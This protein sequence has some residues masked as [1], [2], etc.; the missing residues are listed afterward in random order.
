MFGIIFVQQS[1][2]TQ[3]LTA[4]EHKHFYHPTQLGESCVQVVRTT[5]ELRKLTIFL[6]LSSTF[7]KNYLQIILKLLLAWFWYCSQSLSQSVCGLCLIF[8]IALVLEL[9][10]V[11]FPGWSWSLSWFCSW[12]W[13]EIGLNLSLDFCLGLILSCCGSPTRCQTCCHC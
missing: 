10:M 12:S 8:F 3:P 7:S 6:V 13:S 2:A 4:Q 9:L 11:L 5:N 1:T